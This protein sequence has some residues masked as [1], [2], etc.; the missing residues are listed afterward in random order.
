MLRLR[1]AAIATAVA[2]T[3]AAPAVAQATVMSSTI[4]SWVSSASG[5]P[6]NA[7]YLLSYDNPPDPTTLSVSGV[8]PGA[9]SADQ[10]DIVC[11]FGPE[12]SVG[13]AVLASNVPVS[14]AGTFTTTSPPALRAIAGHACRL[15]AIPAGQ[16]STDDVESFSGPQVA[17]S[18]AGLPSQEISGGPNDDDAYNFYVN[19]TTFSGYAA[20]GPAGSCGPYSAP[21]DA[22]FNTGN[23]AINCMGSLLSDDLGV[24]GGRSEVQVDG[25]N[26]YDAFS[27]QKLFS[28]SQNLPGGFPTLTDSVDWD[29]ATGLMSSHSDEGWVQCAGP[30]PY[31]PTAENCSSFVS[32]GVQLERDVTTSD[33][34]RVVTMTDT[35]SSTDGAAH[36]LDLLYDD[37]VG[38]STSA[39]ERG[40]EFPGQTSFSPYA[41]GDSVPG[42]TAAPG[43]ILVRT[44]AAAPDGDPAEAVGAIT[45]SRA[46][47]EFRFVSNN[48]FE[49][50]N[51]LTIPAGGSTSLTYI[52]SVGYSVAEVTR[53]ALAGE[54]VVRSPAVA[55]N[56][57]VSGATVTTPTVDVSGT[58]SAGSGIV[59]LV[60]AGQTVP[61]GANG[62]WSTRVPLSP[63]AN[64]ITAGA[65]DG[66]GA[67]AQAQVMVVYQVPQAP[68]P[69]APP[70]SRCK[71]PRLKGMKLKAAERALRRAHCG[72]GKI[73]HERSRKAR[74]DRVIGSEPGPGRILVAGAKVELFVSKGR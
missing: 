42:P 46:P 50:R 31:Q 65:T 55:I 17:V 10:V 54:D 73:K 18:E 72:V 23:F 35:W 40:Y 47:S 19:G 28:G 7:S 20:W 43:S 3:A 5:T 33:G 30:D 59:S 51:V 22:S 71:V 57:P 64:T 4:T 61:V 48:E 66:A 60:V 69:P 39:S 27:A 49:E 6:P 67:V 63:G 24:W 15:R 8:A 25:R 14:D 9:N 26:A 13:D 44:N 58:A 16:E 53:L 62:E 74:A 29:P 70:V 45:F 38:L 2:V 11:Y 21:I 34:G 52:Y 36:T 56:S 68:P 32:A 41:A 37:Y 1:I 12:S